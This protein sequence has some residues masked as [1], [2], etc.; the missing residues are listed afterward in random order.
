MQKFITAVMFGIA[1]VMSYPVLSQAADV[2]TL[3]APNPINM[4][5][6]Y[7]NIIL[8]SISQVAESD[9]FLFQGTAGEFIQIT[10]VDL[11]LSSFNRAPI[12]QIFDPTTPIPL[13]LGT[14]EPNGNNVS[15]QLTLTKTGTYRVVVRERGN[16]QTVSYKLAFQRV[17]PSLPDAL[18]LCVGCVLLNSIDPIGDSDVFLFR[19][20]TG[21]TVQLTLTNLDSNGFKVPVAQVFDPI[22][23]TPALIGTIHPGNGARR[24][25]SHL[26]GQGRIG[27]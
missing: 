26:P 22:I 7:G 20:T 15:L 19:G 24:C 11:D 10:L 6:V 12:A 16:D 14:L 25:S 8:C 23:P 2:D 1:M 5:V 9:V 27:L 4:T 21:D 18:A 17:S 13:L 3:C